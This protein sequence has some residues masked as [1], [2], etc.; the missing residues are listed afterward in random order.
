MISFNNAGNEKIKSEIVE[1]YFN[2]L[3][4]M[5]GG[6]SLVRSVPAC[7]RNLAMESETREKIIGM[8]KSG[9]CPLESTTNK[10]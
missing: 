8:Q 5:I 9:V 2:W 3:L 1:R 10:A 6:I 4:P 7:F